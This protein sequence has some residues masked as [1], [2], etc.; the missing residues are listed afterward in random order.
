MRFKSVVYKKNKPFRSTAIFFILALFLSTTLFAETNSSISDTTPLGA[1]VEEF[2]A[3][4]RQM[5]PERAAMALEAEASVA[6]VQGAGALPDPMVGLTFDDIMEN[7]RGL[8]GRLGATKFTLQQ[9]LPWWGKRDVQ[10]DLAES[11]SREALGKLSELD[12]EIALRI[13]TAYADYHRV[14]LSMDQ[15][16]ELVEIMRTLVQLAQLRYAQG[17]ALQQEATSTEAE[18]GAL[19]VELVRLG[20]ERKRIRFRLNALINRKPD[21]PVVEHPHLRPIPDEATLDYHQLLIRATTTN[22]ALT[23]AHARLNT[24]KQNHL[25][26]EKD[27]YP[28]FN[29]GAGFKRPQNSAEKDSFEAMV[30]INLPLQRQSRQA[31]DRATAAAMQAAQETLNY[32]QLRLESTLQEAL[33]TLQEAREVERV[34]TDSLLPQAR[35]ALQSALKGYQTGASEV[36]AVLD[37]IQRLKKFQIALINAQFEQQTRLA[38]IERLI[39]GDL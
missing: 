32:E 1:N 35:L 26:A 10:R 34:T 22:P 28:N 36:I 23:I 37:A 13:K 11:E 30:E 31:Q 33:S 2:L 7:S 9:E 16:S 12:A 6:R 27:W 8:P 25:L 20:H 4:A 19:S 29:L 14:H 21:A 38:E 15:T 5:N 39:G 3:I 18:R 24:A 17:L